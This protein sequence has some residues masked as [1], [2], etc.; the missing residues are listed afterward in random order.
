M[1]SQNE[2]TSRSGNISELEMVGALLFGSISDA[3]STSSAE[4][5]FENEAKNSFSE[6]S[7]RMVNLGARIAP[8]TARDWEENSTPSVVLSASDKDA[9]SE[10]VPERKKPERVLIST[11]NPIGNS[12]NL[13]SQIQTKKTTKEEIMK[14]SAKEAFRGI[15]TRKNNNR[16]QAFSYFYGLSIAVLTCCSLFLGWQLYLTQEN[17]TETKTEFSSL[18]AVDEIVDPETVAVMEP[19]V[20][21]ISI[22]EMEDVP[23]SAFAPIQTE[24]NPT[25]AQVATSEQVSESEIPVFDPNLGI[26]LETAPINPTVGSVVA[27]STETYP[28]FD[29]NLAGTATTQIDAQNPN[30]TK[31]ANQY[32]ADMNTTWNAGATMDEFPTFNS[33]VSDFN[34]SSTQTVPTYA[35]AP[36]PTQIHVIPNA[37][38]PQIA[39][40][41]A[42]IGTLAQVSAIPRKLSAP[43][44]SQTNAYAPAEETYPTFNPNMG[45]DN[46]LP[47]SYY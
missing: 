9:I 33:D 5:V 28:S 36:M 7:R 23:E 42:Q 12:L 22:P 21:P 19:M 35:V 29:A 11:Q 46:S 26:E 34:T 37:N 24:A 43:M 2:T 4:N 40:V 18:R 1:N 41:E 31:N 16:A 6:E 32:A 15:A 10:I 38:A 17:A 27:I 25:F 39:P 30:P 44:A 45:V 13:D 20:E 8:A 14:E 47:V 3:N